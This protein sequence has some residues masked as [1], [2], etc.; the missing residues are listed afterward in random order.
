M[1]GSISTLKKFSPL[2]NKNPIS[3]PHVGHF[4]LYHSLQ[5]YE[6]HSA[7]FLTNIGE[8]SPRQQGM[9]KLKTDS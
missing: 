6:S 2:Y 9:P 4:S 7:P 5:S 3:L 8:V 1:I